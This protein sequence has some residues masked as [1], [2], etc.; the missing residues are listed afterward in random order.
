M[1]ILPINNFCRQYNSVQKPAKKIPFEAGYDTVCFK[2][3]NFLDLPEEEILKKLEA[4]ITP[5]N[6]L[7]KGTVAE[8]YRIKD[9]DYCIRI[10]HLLKG[11]KLAEYSRK[12]EPI[13]KVN[14]VVAKFRNGAS[15]R[16]YFDG[17]VPQMYE[18]KELSKYKL[19]SDI[20][21][22]PLKAYSELLHQIADGINN[23][24]LFDCA[25]GNLI[26]NTDKQTLTAIDFYNINDNPNPIRPLY[27]MYSVLT[28]HGAKE[29]TGKKI[30]DKI[31]DAG[32]NEFKPNNIPCMDVALFDFPEV[33]L[34]RMG[35]AY[36]PDNE[37]MKSLII[38]KSDLL[39]KIKK[40][41]IF[42]KNVSKMLEQH[43]DECRSILKKV[44]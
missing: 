26:V 43:I 38:Y 3:R 34:K 11:D 31:V 6:L 1:K 29:E 28:S 13:D 27:E 2:S 30:F 25:S 15:I 18:N 16:K 7:G 9:T 21:N 4:S 41:E 39:K 8:V 20:S 19:Q 23:E 33:C 22:M 24:M 5:E 42:G 37:K 32:L 40:E 17:I 35:H 12:L 36:T 10:P 44:R 14:H